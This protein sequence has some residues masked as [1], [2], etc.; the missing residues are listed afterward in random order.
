MPQGKLAGS[1]PGY[2]QGF[3]LQLARPCPFSRSGHQA[4]LAAMLADW[5]CA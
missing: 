2:T 1:Q 4:M 3:L 5:R